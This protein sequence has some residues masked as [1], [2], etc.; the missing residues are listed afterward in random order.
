MTTTPR[1]WNA[2]EV[3]TAAML[4]AEI[5]DQFNSIFA[6]WTTYTPTWTATTTDPVL[7]N[8][9]LTGRYLKIGRTCHVS[10]ILT[11]GSTTT[12]GAG[13][14]TFGL[15]F[16][17]ANAIVG[18]LGGARLSAADTWQGQSSM[19][20]SASGINC[21]FATSATNARGANMSGSVPA[22]LA[23]GHVMRAS[24]TYQTAT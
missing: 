2:G 10:M 8:G 1:T 19:G 4:Q 23:A 17:G 18:Y 20:N 24:I 12:L 11:I 7:N 15:P 14:Y 6:A 21:T 5:R 9:V 22:A 16:T 13:A 3:V